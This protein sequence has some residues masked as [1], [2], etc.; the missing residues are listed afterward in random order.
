M[1]RKTWLLILICC[2][3]LYIP[4]ATPSLAIRTKLIFTGHP[5]SALTSKVSIQAR[6]N[7]GY[8]PYLKNHH[9]KA[10][11]ISHPPSTMSVAGANMLVYEDFIVYR[12]GPIFVAKILY[13]ELM[14]IMNV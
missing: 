8:Q 5:V 1:T 13:D 4:H 14:K 11:R 12:K 6:E 9:A 3:I 7:K 10:Y 2:C